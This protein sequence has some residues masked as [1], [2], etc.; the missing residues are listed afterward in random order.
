MKPNA[1]FTLLVA[2]LLC[3]QPAVLTATDT[4]DVF[5]AGQIELAK[6]Q[7]MAG[8]SD[9]AFAT[10]ERTLQACRKV[11]PEDDLL[12]A[13]IYHR[14][15]VF[16]Y[17]LTAHDKAF[18]YLHKALE[19]RKVKLP[20]DDLDHLRTRFATALS[21]RQLGL[22]GLAR[23]FIEPVY[24]TLEAD[25][26]LSYPSRGNLYYE[27]G[28]IYREL[29]DY[30]ASESFL[31]RGLDQFADNPL[32]LARTSNELGILYDEMREYEQSL[33]RLA[34]A[35]DMYRQL[36][37]DAG[38]IVGMINA[39]FNLSA[40]YIDIPDYDK[41]L[42]HLEEAENLLLAN[43]GLEGNEAFYCDILHNKSILWK[44]R[45][46]LQ[47][48]TDL[49]TE[50]IA[51]LTEGLK[52]SALAPKLTIHYDHLGDIYKL[53][54]RIEEAL[55]QYQMA[56]ACQVPGFESKEV[57]QN[58]QMENQL[59]HSS[60]DLFT[61]LSS[62]AG[63]LLQAF[64][65][66]QSLPLLIAAFDTYQTIDALVTKMRLGY[67]G[68]A[69]KFFHSG[70]AYPQ[71]EKAINTSLRLFEITH[72]PGYQRAAWFFAE[73]SK[74]VVLYEAVRKAKVPEDGNL[75]EELLATGEALTSRISSLEAAYF[76]QLGTGSAEELLS[77][78]DQ[79]A[80]GRQEYAA[81]LEEVRSAH[82]EYYQLEY[83]TSEIL[84]LESLQRKLQQR[85][86]LIEYHL[87]RE[88]IYVFAISSTSVEVRSIVRPENLDSIYRQF[89]R[90]VTDWEFVSRSRKE[91]EK[92][93]LES[94]N[95]LFNWLVNP[96]LST[97]STDI[98]RL[99]VVPDGML[100]QLPFEALLTRPA[101]SWKE[102]D[103]P[104]LIRQFSMS[105]A[106]SATLSFH[107]YERSKKPEYVFGGFGLDYRSLTAET[108]LYATASELPYAPFEVR[109][110]AQLFPAKTWLNEEATYANFVEHAPKCGLLHLAMHAVVD[111][112]QH[113]NSY[114]LLAPAE[115][116]D[117]QIFRE[118]EVYD[119][120]LSAEMV[121][122][123]ACQTG[124]G[125]ILQGEGTMS[126]SRAFAYAGAPTLS[127]SLWSI[128]DAS[129]AKIMIAFYKNLAQGM[130]K[131]V[132]LQ[133]AR[134]DYLESVNPESTLPVFWA[135]IVVI[136]NPDPLSRFKRT[137][138]WIWGI[139]IIAAVFLLLY[140]RRAAG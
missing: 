108:D 2:V 97:F 77:L 115:N 139:P 91:A 35:L 27:M 127:M 129:T 110:I 53:Q 113:G 52:I 119:L 126:L 100:T 95:L 67:A 5:T 43:F 1:M 79:V 44:R 38:A 62:K 112:E 10:L 96:A 98:R 103:V 135:G 56:I 25:S 64:E 133:K 81:Y 60:P 57:L 29:G 120:S 46:F 48:A 68:D 50:A 140:Y 40:T 36:P 128:G 130:P 122:L 75:P 78:R 102:R 121:T 125:K 138:Y 11:L 21:C 23:D 45:G 41:S 47:K 114:L 19:I 58:P 6:A 34:Q 88:R 13:S 89:Q 9:S 63:T 86:G 51:I 123:S 104:Y 73:R 3:S 83:G 12:L 7:F 106:W 33:Q 17:S 131:D 15:G 105:Y 99:I 87:G 101:S 32:K 4:L 26:S 42:K 84:S 61:V 69:S 30:E 49:E 65:K 72:E 18:P 117:E 93:Y 70:L 71:Y 92:A 90:S 136:G 37:P 107:P 74:A 20:P 134:L 109:E 55:Q 94:A 76:E 80:V 82:P 14:F 124:A 54:E 16:H 39:H 66:D 24:T 8:D 22:Y 59:I 132:A 31:E 111:E 116:A 137:S 85:T 28:A 118:P